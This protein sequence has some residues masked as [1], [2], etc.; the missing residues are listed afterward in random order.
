MIMVQAHHQLPLSQLNLKVIP[1]T[2]DTQGCNQLL[3]LLSVAFQIRQ[4]SS[5][6]NGDY[7]HNHPLENSG[8]GGFNYQLHLVF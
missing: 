7:S 3:I 6:H 1:N 4:P 2:V 5:P 8:K